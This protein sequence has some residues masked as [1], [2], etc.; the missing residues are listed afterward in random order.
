MMKILRFGLIFVLCFLMASF[1]FS[2][3][4]LQQSPVIEASPLI[5]DTQQNYLARVGYNDP[6]E[7]ENALIRAE[8][9][10]QNLEP[11]DLNVEPIA[12][13]LHGPEVKIF[14]SEN[15]EAYKRIV[16]LAARLSALGV[17]DIRVCE[18]RSRHMRLELETLYPF[19]GTV[20]FAPKEIDRLISKEKYL[21]F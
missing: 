16:D 2:E 10:Y 6:A 15:Y 18:A 11:Q 7:L 8:Q 17:L 20:E 4:F 1:A 9:F 12:F 5:L 14:F 13:V 19:V 3:P 21:Y